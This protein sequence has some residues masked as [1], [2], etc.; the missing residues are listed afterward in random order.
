MH[1]IAIYLYMN[2]VPKNA[3][4]RTF[5]NIIASMKVHHLRFDNG[6]DDPRAHTS[7]GYKWHLASGS[8]IFHKSPCSQNKFTVYPE[9][10]EVMD[11]VTEV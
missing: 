10:P 8:T 3:A 7:K 4:T 1:A 5:K 6:R 11:L 9:Q 2:T